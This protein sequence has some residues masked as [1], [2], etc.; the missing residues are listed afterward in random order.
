MRKPHAALAATLLAATTLAA[1]DSDDVI[2]VTSTVTAPVTEEAAVTESA[3]AT[4]TPTPAGPLVRDAEDFRIIPD[5]A[6][7]AYA[8]QVSPTT[9]CTY[10]GK[11]LPED[12]YFD[13]HVELTGN[14]PPLDIDN[15][16]DADPAALLWDPSIG[17]VA[18]H[19]LG[20]SEGVPPGVKLHPGEQVTIA[21]YTFTQFANGTARVEREGHWFEVDPTGQFSSDRF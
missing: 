16:I 6:H 18:A 1:C 13:C 14:I 15:G 20:G 5:A 19:N 9:M 10:F 11:E 3:T 12:A 4:G 21:E 17:F 8:V 2:E 7:S